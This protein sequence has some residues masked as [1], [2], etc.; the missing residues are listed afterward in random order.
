MYGV[1][2]LRNALSGAI[3]STDQSVTF[4]NSAL[5]NT[6]QTFTITV[7]E[8]GICEYMLTVYNPSTVTDLTVKV[9]AEAVSLGGASRD[10]LLATVYIPKSQSI[11]GTTVNCNSKLLHGIFC[12]TDM[13]IIASNDTALG[14]SDGFQSTF[15]I[16]EVA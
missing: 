15:R 8:I 12:A 2:V 9:F 1:S 7:P 5:I 4:A 13:K 3:V 16:R 6:Q 10:A 11:S 14:V